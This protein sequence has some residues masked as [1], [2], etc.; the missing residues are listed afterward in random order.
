MEKKF[1]R[2]APF[3]CEVY[4]DLLVLMTGEEWMLN[5]TCKPLYLMSDERT[6]SSYITDDI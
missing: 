3:G 1:L 2:E 6:Q 4:I 5:F